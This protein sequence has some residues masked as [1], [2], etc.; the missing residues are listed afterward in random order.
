MLFDGQVPNGEE[1]VSCAR[2]AECPVHVVGV[3]IGPNDAMRA[4]AEETG[5]RAVF[6]SSGD[7][8]AFAVER[9]SPLQTPPL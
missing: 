5:G 2:E 1:I 3:A 6:L 7:Y 9:F 4:V 8:I